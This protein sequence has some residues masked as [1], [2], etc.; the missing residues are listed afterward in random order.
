[1]VGR[2]AKG[3][4]GL[5]FVCER[6]AVRLCV[7]CSLRT[8]SPEKSE[9]GWRGGGKESSSQ[10]DSPRLRARMCVGG[11]AVALVRRPGANAWLLHAVHCGL[12]LS[13]E[14]RAGHSVNAHT[15]Y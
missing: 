11:T 10:G 12:G 1:M 8:V 13:P 15:A 9:A 14:T 4:Q 7:G 5:R 3:V 2:I 6:R